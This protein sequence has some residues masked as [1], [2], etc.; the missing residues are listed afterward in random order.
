M[1]RR[2]ALPTQSNGE[3]AR[4]LPQTHSKV[5]AF[6]GQRSLVTVLCAA[7]IASSCVSAFAQGAGD[8]KQAEQQKP[9]EPKSEAA[10]LADVARTLSGQAAL[11][12]CTHLGEFAIMRMAKDDMD[13]AFRYMD[14]YDRFGCPGKHIQESFRCLLL[15]GIPNSKD[16]TA[17]LENLVRNCWAPKATAAAPAAPAAPATPAPASPPSTAGA[18]AR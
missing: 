18:G 11:P 2:A 7:F 13:T 9:P 5:M 4:K 10:H 16:S 8:A 12:E 14:L 3:E 6:T 1:G 17:S 15:A